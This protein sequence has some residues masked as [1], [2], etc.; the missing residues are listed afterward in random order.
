VAGPP[1]PPWPT[2][3]S[4]LTTWADHWNTDLK[5]FIWKATAAEIVTK[6]QQGRDALDQIKSTTDR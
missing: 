2:S 1:R 3:P 6:G 5:P 4:A